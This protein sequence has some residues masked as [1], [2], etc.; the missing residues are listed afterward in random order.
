MNLIMKKCRISSV[1]DFKIK[2]NKES[3][4]TLRKGYEL[5]CLA[6]MQV[7]MQFE[8]KH[9]PK[10][11]NFFF[12]ASLDARDI[13]LPYLC[14]WQQGKPGSWGTGGRFSWPSHTQSVSSTPKGTKKGVRQKKGLRY[15]IGA[16]ANLSF[17]F[18]LYGL[19]MANK[20]CGHTLL[21][22]E[23][24]LFVSLNEHTIVKPK[25]TGGA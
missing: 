3:H 24:Y 12:F 25:R 14:S 4:H 10:K 6:M 16:S 11:K 7:V 8:K 5:S 9:D 1:H 13:W 20:K 22:S 21:S 23:N 18:A 15:K 2:T 19:P 17:M